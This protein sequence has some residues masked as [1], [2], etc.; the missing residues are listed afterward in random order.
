M[1]ID[2]PASPTVG[3]QYTYGGGTYTFSGSMWLA[4]AGVVSEV[5]SGSLMMFQQ[6]AAPMGWVKQT[7]YDDRTL[8]IVSDTAGRG[9]SLAF[10]TLFTRTAVDST[11]LSVAQLPYHG[12]SVPAYNSP[13]IGGGGT[14]LQQS[15]GWAGSYGITYATGSSGAHAH[16]LDMRVATVDSIV[17]SKS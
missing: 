2:F 17:A 14:Y 12:H 16:G 5:A 3:Q 1:P 7:E 10:S 4:N 13:A 9:G 8:R 15:G 6:T 11:T